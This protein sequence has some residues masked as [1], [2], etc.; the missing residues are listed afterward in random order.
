MS[1]NATQDKEPTD[2]PLFDGAE[3]V[4]YS[5]DLEQ[6]H[7]FDEADGIPGWC[8]ETNLGSVGLWARWPGD[9]YEIPLFSAAPFGVWLSLDASFYE[10]TT[11]E[12]VTEAFVEAL[13]DPWATTAEQHEAMTDAEKLVSNMLRH[14]VI[15]GTPSPEMFGVIEWCEERAGGGEP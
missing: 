5:S 11:W 4:I 3:L 1:T 13:A 15:E 8:K 14:S 7:D 9:G 6:N 10:N 12:P 2:E